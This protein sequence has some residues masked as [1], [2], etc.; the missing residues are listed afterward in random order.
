ME[1]VKYKRLEPNKLL[2][3]YC[4]PKNVRPILL[5]ANIPRPD[6]ICA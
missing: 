5:I 3:N 4:K 1:Q 6:A 2:K